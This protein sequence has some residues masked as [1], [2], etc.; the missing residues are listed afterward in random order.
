M[1][2]LVVPKSYTR[3]NTLFYQKFYERDEINFVALGEQLV[4]N[5]LLF[6]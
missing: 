2:S 5:L 4:W 6:L 1:K 3:A